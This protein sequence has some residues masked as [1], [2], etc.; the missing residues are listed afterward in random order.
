M[1]EIGGIELL[2]CFGPF[3]KLN[4]ASSAFWLVIKM[5][6]LVEDFIDAPSEEVLDKCTKEQLLKLAEY[7]SSYMQA[8]K[9]T[10]TQGKATLFM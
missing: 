2:F 7:S 9:K 8:I 6:S 4:Q 5:V 10:H 3:W 1:A